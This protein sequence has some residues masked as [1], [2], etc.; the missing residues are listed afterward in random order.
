[1]LFDKSKKQD[2]QHLTICSLILLYV[3]LVLAYNIT[4]R[5]GSFCLQLNCCNYE[6]YYVFCVKLRYTSLKLVNELNIKL[7]ESLIKNITF[8]E[9]LIK[10]ITLYVFVTK[11][12]LEINFNL[13]ISQLLRLKYIKYLRDLTSIII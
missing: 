13:L 12:L 9:S 5:V 2:T 11:Y 8:F 6:R 7:F 1:V 3:H 10:N 4:Y